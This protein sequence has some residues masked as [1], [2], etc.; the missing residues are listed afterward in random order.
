MSEELSEEEIN[1]KIMETVQA[2]EEI[3]ERGLANRLFKKLSAKITFSVRDDWI[4]EQICSLFP[5]DIDIRCMVFCCSPRNACPYR[6]AVLKKI[7]WSLED[8]IN[9]KKKFAEDLEGV[10]K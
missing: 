7:G 9:L 1:A 8:Y 2:L 3:G 5:K 10:F 4:N 6:A